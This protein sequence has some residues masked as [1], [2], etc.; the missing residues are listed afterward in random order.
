[1][2]LRKKTTRFLLSLCF[3]GLLVF[4]ASAKTDTTKVTKKAEK[5]KVVDT[6]P[7]FPPN[8]VPQLHVDVIKDRLVCLNT[9]IKLT[10][11]KEIMRWVKF[12]LIK[13]RV[14]TQK[15]LEKSTFYFPIFEEALKRHN[16]PVELKYLPIVESALRP[17]AVSW[18][19]AAG[20][21]QFIPSTGR[22]Y[23]L[24][25]DWYIDERYDIYKATDA[26]CRYLKFLYNYHGDWQLALAA[27]NC[28]PGRV[29][30]AVKKAG[31]KNNFW[32]IYRYLPRE[33][34]GYVPAFIGVTYVMNYADKHNIYA[35][36]PVPPIPSDTIMVSNFVNIQQFAKQIDVPLG[37]MQILNAHL[38]KNAIPNYKRNYPLRY[39]AYKREMVERFRGRI[40]SSSRGYS[41]RG[42]GY[43]AGRNQYGGSKR[44]HRVKRGE[45][46][47]LIALRYGTTVAYLRVWNR[48]RSNMVYP[49]QKLVI[50][51]K[52]PRRR[53]AKLGQNFIAAVHEMTAKESKKKKTVVKKKTVK[54][55][56]AKTAVT[57]TK[58]SSKTLVFAT[59]ADIEKTAKVKQSKSVAVKTDHSTTKQI[60]KK[61]AKKTVKKEPLT[62]A[63]TFYANKI[64]FK[65]GEYQQLVAQTPKDVRNAARAK[66][67]KT[68]IGKTLPRRKAK[69]KKRKMLQNIRFH[70]VVRGDTLW[71]IA[72]RNGLTIYQLKKLNNLN[73]RSVLVPG[74]KLKVSSR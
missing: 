71:T 35:K 28:G 37:V 56:V 31:G 59:T 66:E 2:C 5:V 61:V 30:W 55:T 29:D 23:G 72:R 7:H 26:A 45:S 44:V 25:Q 64:K 20:L 36:R 69:S 42:L 41:R 18:A 60:E 13:N 6:V 32:K 19:A 68:S 73:N 65:Q 39:P 21:W 62:A 70:R 52:P 12:Y 47:A 40:V 8:Y 63:T 74:Q 49:N 10:Y 17:R 9:S 11:S 4:D 33:T 43:T 3:T 16:M 54:T 58:G 14:T 53:S 1:M 46:L 51:S 48:L 57:R 34:R 38:K 27:Y 67:R 50:Y 24:K 22:E 15:L